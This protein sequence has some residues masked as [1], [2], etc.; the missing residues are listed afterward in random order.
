MPTPN[1]E[2]Y[3][4]KQNKNSNTAHE[5]RRE[6]LYLE[7]GSCNRIKNKILEESIGV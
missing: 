5:F 7:E 3:E 6:Y 1:M 2:P 4:D